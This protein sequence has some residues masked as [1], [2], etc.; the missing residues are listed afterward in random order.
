MAVDSTIPMKR[1]E[2][3]S[4]L[5]A[6]NVAWHP[7]NSF[8][9][10]FGYL[11]RF[12]AWYN[13]KHLLVKTLSYWSRVAPYLYLRGLARVGLSP[14]THSSSF[15]VSK[16]E[17]LEYCTLGNILIAV[18]FMLIFNL[19]IELYQF[20]NMPPGP[21]LTTLPFIGNLLSFDS[22]E[23]LREATARFVY[24]SSSLHSTSNITFWL[25]RRSRR[26]RIKEN[27]GS[28]VFGP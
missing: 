9:G 3:F 4:Q 19:L 2:D 12:N 11:Q 16:M 25:S 7:E 23:S 27:K 13:K 21:R 14:S 6:K 26:E 1:S 15:I 20:R 17:M 10:Y 24:K 5:S 28:L 8:T 18:I 22:G